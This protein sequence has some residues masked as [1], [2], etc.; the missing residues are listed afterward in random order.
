MSDIIAT[1][2]KQKGSLFGDQAKRDV[3]TDCWKSRNIAAHLKNM[4]VAVLAVGGWHDAEDPQGPLTTYR[5]IR[6]HNPDTF[7]AIVMGPWSHG[8]WGRLDGAQL[9]RVNIA[10]KTGDHYRKKILF[11]FFE[12][13]LRDKEPA[14]DAA[15]DKGET[16][17]FGAYA[18]E[19]GP[20]A[21]PEDFKKATQRVY[22]FA[23][24]ASGIAVQMLG[25]T[26]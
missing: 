13:F 22:R 20:E 19:T 14:K 16:K 9:G 25:G 11:P 21:K 18:F 6:Q 12:K 10:A 17:L 26:R 15:K 4:K 5:S 3:Y 23:S 24:Q 1:P 2:E 7:N 8:A